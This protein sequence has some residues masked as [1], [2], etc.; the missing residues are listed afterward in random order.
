MKLVSEW[1]AVEDYFMRRLTK[2]VKFTCENVPV[3]LQAHCA[4]FEA[5]CA[6]FEPFVLIFNL[7]PLNAK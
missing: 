2:T 7:E 1:G 5:H 6:N 3:Q 4:N